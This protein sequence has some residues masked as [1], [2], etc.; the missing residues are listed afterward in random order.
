M[1]HFTS[2]AFREDGITQSVIANA[3]PTIRHDLVNT[4]SG[5]LTKLI[6]LVN[7]SEHK[8][9]VSQVHLGIGK[10]CR[11]ITGVIMMQTGQ[12]LDLPVF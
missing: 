8:E 7:A 6:C 4:L 5:V 1:K 2:Q 10:Y 12:I 9:N 3:F 11:L